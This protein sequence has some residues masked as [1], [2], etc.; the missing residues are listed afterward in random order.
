MRR[1]VWE[2]RRGRA[3]VAP[4]DQRVATRSKRSAEGNQETNDQPNL[5]LIASMTLSKLGGS[6][7]GG[8]F[9]LPTTPGI[10]PSW[11]FTLNSVNLRPLAVETQTTFSPFLITLR[12]T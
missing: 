4:Q 6:R 5:W 10:E 7:T 8:F 11:Y 2:T 12:P 9:S 3:P 1:T